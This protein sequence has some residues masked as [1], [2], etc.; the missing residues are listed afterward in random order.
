MF[1]YLLFMV[2]LLFTRSNWRVTVPCLVI[3]FFIVLGAVLPA[4]NPSMVF[5]TRPITIEFVFG[6]VLALTFEKLPLFKAPIY[7]LAAAAAIAVMFIC[8]YPLEGHAS[9]FRVLVWGIPSAVLVLSALSLESLGITVTWNPLIL[10]GEASYAIY[11][12]HYSVAQLSKKFPLPVENAI[13]AVAM[14][15]VTMCLILLVGVV[16][17]YLFDKPVAKALRRLPYG[18]RRK[19]LLPQLAD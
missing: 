12:T 10:V 2:G 3:T 9:Y 8:P 15:A 6:I 1:F 16:V 19:K 14:T 17:Y 18:R 13:A 4:I 11:L 5:I 7:L